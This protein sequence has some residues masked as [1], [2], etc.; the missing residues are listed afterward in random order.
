MLIG[1]L[2]GACPSGAPE[3]PFYVDSQQTISEDE[4]CAPFVSLESALVAAAEL[5]TASISLLSNENFPTWT[6][7]NTLSI[8][9][10]SHILTLT[11]PISVPGRLNLASTRLVSRTNLAIEVTGTLS[12]VNCEISDFLPVPVLAKG[13]V[14][15]SNSHFKGNT[16][17]VLYS[18]SLGGIVSVTQSEFRDNAGDSGAVFYISPQGGLTTTRYEI[19]NC[20]FE[21]NGAKAPG[22]LLTLS[23][24]EIT[25]AAEP[26]V[27]SF[28]E[29][30]FRRN[31]RTT[32][33]IMNKKFNFIAEKCQ[34]F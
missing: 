6:A 14:F 13:L 31:T 19:A 25:E 32:F 33:Q 27:V 21:G 18:P 24:L 9:G 16:K 2:A 26:Q 34:F 23:G 28:S 15:I 30:I 11:G 3:F 8:T 1:T 4:G 17:G 29:C 20:L 12:M 5:T 22:S 7:L 10:N